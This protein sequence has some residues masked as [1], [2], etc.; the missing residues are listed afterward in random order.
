MCTS[1]CA[2]A[3]P[4]SCCRWPCF[5]GVGA[6]AVSGTGPQGGGLPGDP[7][8]GGS[9]DAPQ[10]SWTWRA[11]GEELQRLLEKRGA[12]LLWWG[13]RRLGPAGR[14]GVRA[15]LLLQL[16]GLQQASGL[17]SLPPPSLRGGRSP[18]PRTDF[19]CEVPLPALRHPL[20]VRPWT[21]PSRASC[22][23]SPSFLPR[24]PELPGLGWPRPRGAGR[25]RCCGHLACWDLACCP[26]PAAWVGVL[27][28]LH[29]TPS[30]I[31]L[32]TPCHL[33]HGVG[34]SLP[35]TQQWGQ[36]RAGL[37]ETP[38]RA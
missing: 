19:L 14:C 1:G 10:G 36:G 24:T 32:L 4:G 25:G 26:C 37:R 35:A 31:H 22:P 23:L 11:S 16:G 15:P 38:A 21:A 13:L 2:W 18:H 17:P 9:P 30:G 3:C 33:C 8:A 27:V 6:G 20:P 29:C 28:P 34:S 12:L 7:V 5:R